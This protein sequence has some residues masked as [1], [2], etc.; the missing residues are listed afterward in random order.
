VEAPPNS[1]ANVTG[2]L[3]NYWQ[4]N[5][6]RVTV[7]VTTSVIPAFTPRMHLHRGRCHNRLRC[8]I[9][10]RLPDD[11]PVLIVGK[12]WSCCV[13]G[14]ANELNPRQPG[15]RRRPN[16]SNLTFLTKICVRHHHP[17]GNPKTHRIARLGFVAPMTRSRHRRDADRSPSRILF[18][19]GIVSGVDIG[20]RKRSLTVNLNDRFTHG[21]SIMM[22]LGRRLGKATRM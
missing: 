4:A 11:F 21:P 9:A 20:D 5:T 8:I 18:P 14:K 22:H 12:S 2:V 6:T 3:R 7:S 17:S 16:R 13:E 15:R 1:V 19:T 10:R